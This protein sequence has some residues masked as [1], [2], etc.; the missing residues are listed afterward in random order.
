MLPVAIVGHIWKTIFGLR[1]ENAIHTMKEVL[2]RK[3][4]NLE[5][6]Q[7]KNMEQLVSF[8]EK[9]QIAMDIEI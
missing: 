7:R 8:G 9:H 4:S 1:M 3:M 2:V 6:I 5:N